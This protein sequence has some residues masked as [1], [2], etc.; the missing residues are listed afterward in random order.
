MTTNRTPERGPHGLKLELE[1]HGAGE[2]GT[3][4]ISY[5]DLDRVE[6][7]IARIDEHGIDGASILALAL[8]SEVAL[9]PSRQV[10]D[11][12]FKQREIKVHRVCVELHFESDKRRHHFPVHAHWAR[13]HRWGCRH[14]PIAHDACANLELRL[15]APDGPALNELKPIGASDECLV[16]WLVKPGSEP[17]GNR[18]AD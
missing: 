1:W 10:K 7:L 8:D 12:Q 6:L 11:L 16:V 5:E 9:D 17:N 2:A 13:V 14:F 15:G 4:P 18:S 3:A